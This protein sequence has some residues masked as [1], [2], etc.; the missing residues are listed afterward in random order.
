V[1]ETAPSKG[2]AHSKMEQIV[3]QPRPPDHWMLWRYAQHLFHSYGELWLGRG[4]ADRALAYAEEC[5]ALA[6][7][8]N[9]TKNIVKACRLRGQALLAQERLV[10]AE[11]EIARALQLAQELGNPPQLWKTQAALGELRRAQGKAEEARLAY[12]AAV[13]TIDQV[14]RSLG[15]ATLHSTFL[16]SAH[17]RQICVC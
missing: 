17:V 1:T 2:A 13:T 10:E 12:Q 15:D 9:S 14:A 6:E 3:R 11:R 4:D 16:S 7:P 8:S 5:L